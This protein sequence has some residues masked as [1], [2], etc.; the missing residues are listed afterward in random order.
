[1]NQAKYRIQMRPHPVVDS[2]GGWDSKVFLTLDGRP[3]LRPCE[4]SVQLKALGA[5]T[6]QFYHDFDVRSS[7]NSERRPPRFP[8][9]LFGDPEGEE[10]SKR[11]LS[12]D[13]KTKNG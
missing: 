9:R 4:N 11:Q 2:A 1:M 12:P 5:F 3:L 13:L 6:S 10:D 7:K 8:P